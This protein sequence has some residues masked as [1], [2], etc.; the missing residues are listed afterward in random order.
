MRSRVA[1]HEFIDKL[2]CIPITR[3]SIYIL[4]SGLNVL[5]NIVD[6]YQEILE[7]AWGGY[8]PEHRL[9]LYINV[10]IKD[11]PYQGLHPS[12]SEFFQFNLVCN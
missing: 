3:N 6:S 11:L 7:I 2:Y 1:F 9:E 5:N 4:V 8:I 10:S 12:F